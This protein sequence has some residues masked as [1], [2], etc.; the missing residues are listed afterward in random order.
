MSDRPRRNQRRRRTRR[1]TQPDTRQIFGNSDPAISRFETGPFPGM[2]PPP[3]P[4]LMVQLIETATGRQ[5]DA[6]AFAAYERVR[7]Y[8]GYEWELGAE[9]DLAR[10]VLADNHDAPREGV[11]HTTAK[12]SSGRTA[13]RIAASRAPDPRDLGDG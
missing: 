7:A 9:A 10:Y 11:P 13:E 8:V 12:K 5:F 6:A 4:P 2:E 3:W 1:S